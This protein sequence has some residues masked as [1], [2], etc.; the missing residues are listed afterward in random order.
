MPRPFQHK[1]H[2]RRLSDASIGIQLRIRQ[3]LRQSHRFVLDDA[4]ARE[5]CNLSHE[6]ERL[7]HWAFIARLPHDPMWIVFPSE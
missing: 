6:H 4:S 3:K 5:L 2:R 1:L 7:P